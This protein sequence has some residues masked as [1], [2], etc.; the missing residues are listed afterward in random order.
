M[1]NRIRLLVVIVAA[2]L[3]LSACP[4]PFFM[5]AIDLANKTLKYY[6]NVLA[7]YGSPTAPNGH[8]LTTLAFDG[9][10]KA[11]TFEVALFGF[12]FA[13][14]T[15]VDSGKYTDKTWFQADGQTG[16]FA[17]DPGTSLLTLTITQGY[18]P[19]VGAAAMTNGKYASASY[20]YRALNDY[21]SFRDSKTYTAASRTISGSLVVTADNIYPVYPA[22]SAANT[23]TATATDA[24]SLT[25]AGVTTVTQG[26]VVA[27]YV[28]TDA[29]IT[30]D[31]SVVTTTTVGTA[32]PTKSTIRQG[33]TLSVLKYFLAGKPDNPVQTFAEV[34]SKGNDVSFQCERTHT[35]MMTYTGDTPPTLQPV[36]PTTGVV[37]DLGAGWMYSVDDNHVTA[38]EN[39]THGGTYMY[40]TSQTD[41]PGRS[42]HALK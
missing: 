21:L 9:S 30:V 26:D 31:Q 23:W 8:D 1:K 28:V 6:S 41:N 25:E 38:I 15:A 14:Q 32:A 24:V 7:L 11:G 4:A 33:Q 40:D 22:G 36:D 2:A 29:S 5:G 16:T 12:D 3:A 34:W 27:T 10:G 39:L 19:A 35:Y 20:A 17:Y 13:T 18:S 37:S 42:L